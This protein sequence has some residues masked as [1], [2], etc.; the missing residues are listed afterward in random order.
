MA[1]QQPKYHIKEIPPAPVLRVPW[2]LLLITVGVLAGVA[3]G[4][5][6]LVQRA[7]DRADV[8]EVMR[9]AA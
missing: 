3:A 4:G 9:L 6:L 8:A 1:K 5:A 2:I 7:A